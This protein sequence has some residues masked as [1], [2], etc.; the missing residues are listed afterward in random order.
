MRGNSCIR[1]PEETVDCYV[2]RLRKHASSCQFG[3]LT[4]EM[5]RGRLVIGIQDN[6]T[7]ARLLRENDLP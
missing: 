1:M 3:T 4:E 7:K 6:G 5:I 2:N